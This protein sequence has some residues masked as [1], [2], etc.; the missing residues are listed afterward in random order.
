VLEDAYIRR[1]GGTDKIPIDVRYIFSTNKDL[2]K[3]VAEGAFREDLY[4]RISVVPVTIPPLRERAEDITLIAKYYIDEFNKKLMKKV[5]NISKEAE[6]ILKNYPWPGNVRELKNIIERVMILQDIG[7]TITPDN[8]PAEIKSGINY[9][10]GDKNINLSL[11][12]YT[13]EKNN[14]D[15]ITEKIINNFKKAILNNA[16]QT[17]NGN[18]TKAAKHLGISRYKFI[19]EEKKI[20][21]SEV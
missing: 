10:I 5:K 20:R 13:A 1:V 11:L 17:S 21:S 9:I 16:L 14:Y 8:L 7:N 4:Y 6:I 3:M 19:R 15:K 18:K 12:P 2:N